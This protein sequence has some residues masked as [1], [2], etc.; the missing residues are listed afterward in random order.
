MSARVW[1]EGQTRFFMEELGM[2]RLQLTQMIKVYP[3]VL[4]LSVE[5]KIRP[6][7]SF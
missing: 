6:N 2:R 3:Q 7:V 4:G 5:N 1:C